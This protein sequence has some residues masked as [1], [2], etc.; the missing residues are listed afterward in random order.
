MGNARE[1]L[2]RY[3][4]QHPEQFSMVARTHPFL[5]YFSCAETIYVRASED[6]MD[7]IHA[8]MVG[9]SGTPY[10]D[11]LF[12]FDLQLP[13]SYPAVPPLVYYH[14]FGLRLN[15]NLYE[16][17][18]VCLSLLNTFG[19]E[20]TELWSPV[21]STLLQVLVSIQGLVLNDQPY[22]NEAGY[23]KIGRAHV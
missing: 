14:S 2:T 3:Y 21:T 7:L 16:S 6:H 4:Y 22:Y 9:A 18:T 13:P 11:G 15:P 10:Q 1:R 20:G 12:F 23:E 19:G 17:G 8:V 5:N